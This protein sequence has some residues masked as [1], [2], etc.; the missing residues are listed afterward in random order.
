MRGYFTHR[1]R[2]VRDLFK[3]HGAPDL[4]FETYC[5]GMPPSG[6]K[7]QLVTLLLNDLLPSRGRGGDAGSYNM[8]PFAAKRV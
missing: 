7:G 6:V 8:R 3:S 2:A 4:T 1:G 5:S